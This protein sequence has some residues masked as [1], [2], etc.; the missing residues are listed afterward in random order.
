MSTAAAKA[1]WH[2]WLVGVFALLFNSIGVF[3]FVMSMA[4]GATYLAR[5]G[6]TPEQIAHYLAMPAWMTVVW[7][8]GVFGAFIASILLLLRWRQAFAVFAL[9]LAAFV[10]SLVYTH[11]LMDGGRIMGPQMTV[12]SA[13]IAGLLVLFGAYAQLMAR[14]GLLR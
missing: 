4:Q 11:V 3:D 10:L 13:V 6:M 12:M 2:L 8:V 1:P 7:A 9:S 5:A 14:R